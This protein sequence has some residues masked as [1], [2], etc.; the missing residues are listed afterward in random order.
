MNVIAAV[1][2][3]RRFLSIGGKGGFP[4]ATGLHQSLLVDASSYR[5]D[6]PIGD[7]RS[8]DGQHFFKNGAEL[9]KW[10]DA[11]EG[12]VILTA[13]QRP[14][15]DMPIDADFFA[16]GEIAIYRLYGIPTQACACFTHLGYL[17]GDCPSYP[18][19][20]VTHPQFHCAPP[21]YFL[22]P[23]PGSVFEERL[24]ALTAIEDSVSKKP[25]ISTGE[26]TILSTSAKEA[27][28]DGVKKI[29]DLDGRWHPILEKEKVGKKVES[30]SA[31][32]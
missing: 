19:E 25:R 28:D 1:S 14:P 24:D 2:S 29:K 10:Q 5:A 4:S 20:F 16:E 30:H 15:V 11:I 12:D 3:K 21:D 27:A 17:Y 13:V 22:V 8:A 32:L 26:E 31:M 7:L 18:E 23:K 9:R 6:M